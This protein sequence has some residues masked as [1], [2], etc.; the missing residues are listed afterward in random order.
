MTIRH[1]KVFFFICVLSHIG[2]FIIRNAEGRSDF[3]L[4]FYRFIDVP[5]I[6]LIFLSFCFGVFLMWLYQ[7][8]SLPSRRPVR[9]KSPKGQKEDAKKTDVQA[10]SGLK[11]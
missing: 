9:E 2:F 4:I 6:F 10:K 5:V 3:D 7:L 8:F 11:Q 1:I